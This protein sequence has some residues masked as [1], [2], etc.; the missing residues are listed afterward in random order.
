MGES[1]AVPMH[2]A[3]IETSW[4]QYNARCIQ[5]DARLVRIPCVWLPVLGEPDSL[6][7]LTMDQHVF[8]LLYLGG[9]TRT[10][11]CIVG[12]FNCICRNA[13]I[14]RMRRTRLP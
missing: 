12:L 13:K 1:R 8:G 11:R 5:Y 10:H 4:M 14:A 3:G 9:R 2:L 7:A 6:D